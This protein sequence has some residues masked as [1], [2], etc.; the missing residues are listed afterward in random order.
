MSTIPQDSPQKQCNKCK[1]FKPLTD[2]HLK[3]ASPDGYQY[4]CKQCY[5][6]PYKRT[7]YPP[8]PDG[9]KR[10]S[11]CKEVKQATNDEFVRANDKKSGLSAWCKACQ[12]ARYAAK[13]PDV[14]QSYSRQHYIERKEEVRQWGIQYREVNADRIRL[15]YQEQKTRHAMNSKR[16]RTFNYN[17]I[18]VRNRN[19][20]ALKKAAVGTHTEQDIQKQYERQKGRCY[21]CHAKITKYHVD[22]VVP[23]TRG[24]SNDP[25]NL[26]IACPT[27]NISKH[28]KLLHEWVYGG[29]LL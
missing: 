12:N 9:Y 21:Y 13:D 11:K 19:R 27:C 14:K 4:R 17:R 10:C 16:Y 25:S 3:K 5:I 20:H 18:L 24:G 1:L 2:F 29:R 23:L 15:R 7:Q 22:H 6:K 8:V 28:N 26:V